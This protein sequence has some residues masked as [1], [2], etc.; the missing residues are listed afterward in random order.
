MASRLEEATG[1]AKKMIIGCGIIVVIILLYTFISRL[2][3]SE[4]PPYNPLPTVADYAFGQLPNIEFESIEIDDRS[5]PSFKLD[6]QDGRL[7]SFYPVINV[8][9]TKTPHQSLTA[10]DDALAKA[11]ALNFQGAPKTI[12]ST[13]LKWTNG[14]RTLKINK[15]YNTAEI[16][17]DYTKDELAGQD[18]GI[19]PDYNIYINA[20]KNILSGA[21]LLPLAYEEGKTAA[22]YLTLNNKKELRRAKSASDANFVRIDFFKRMESLT[23]IIPLYT[24]EEVQ[25]SYLELTEYAYLSSHNPNEGLIY[26]VL[27][28]TNAAQ[29]VYE[30]KFTDWEIETYATYYLSPIQDAWDKIQQNEGYLR[31]LMEPN[32]DPNEPY[33][34]LSVNE[35]WVTNIGIAYYSSID[36]IDYIQPVYK[37]S[38]IAML[39]YDNTKADF[40]FLYPAVRNIEY[41]E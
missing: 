40:V 30:L 24:A 4:P 38:G 33:T 14:A 35:Y 10:Q 39:A 26:V 31:Y 18:H 20:A 29:D 19:Q 6:T 25:E 17:T 37:F 13:E 7:P 23:P 12:S 32:A 1:T 3:K 8:H 16:T 41:S 5:S 9:K 15:L 34:P 22:T 2:I 27:G 36:Y 28:G 21:N 11:K